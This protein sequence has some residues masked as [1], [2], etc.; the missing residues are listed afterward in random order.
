[1]DFLLILIGLALL[2]FGGE[3]LLRG[4][5][6]LAE[7]FNLSTLLVSM[8]IVGFGT[9]APELIVSVTSALEGA[10]NLALGNIVGS[11]IANVLL[12]LGVAAVLAPIA[13]GRPEIKRDAMAVLLAS[14]ALVALAQY[15]VI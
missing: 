11:N 2:F 4:C 8:V 3:A 10:P 7:R 13:C 5:V 6:A 15:G 12:I 9:S 1:M 14:L